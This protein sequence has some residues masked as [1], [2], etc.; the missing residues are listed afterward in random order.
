MNYLSANEF[1]KNKFGHKV[2]KISLD[3]GC[4][5]PNRDGTKSVGGCIFCSASGSGEF[6][7]D[8]NFSILDQISKAKELVKNKIKNLENVKQ[9]YIAYF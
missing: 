7:Q 2:Y 1:Y 6:S 5:C 8:K 3:A 4:T 9:K